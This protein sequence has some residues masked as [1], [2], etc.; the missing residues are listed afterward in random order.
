MIVPYNGY[1]RIPDP[2]RW[3]TQNPT[4]FLLVNNT[5]KEKILNI[6]MF[7]SFFSDNDTQ[8]VVAVVVFFWTDG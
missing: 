1:D 5:E 2:V 3:L 7:A 6:A 4:T 8:A